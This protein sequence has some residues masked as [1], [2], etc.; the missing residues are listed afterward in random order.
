MGPGAGQR[1]GSEG[2]GWKPLAS[3][4]LSANGLSPPRGLLP[5]LPWALQGPRQP[6]SPVSA[7]FQALSWGEEGG[8]TPRSTR[9]GGFICFLLLV[10]CHIPGDPRARA[11]TST[12]THSSSDATPPPS[13]WSQRSEVAQLWQ[14][15][16]ALTQATKGPAY[17]VPCQPAAHP[18]PPSLEGSQGG[19][20]SWVGP[21]VSPT[22]S[23]SAWGRSPVSDT[24]SNYLG[25]CRVNWA[26][27]CHSW[28]DL[29]TARC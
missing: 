3:L 20:G 1:L 16:S 22:A 25:L 8:E 21:W 6:T 26:Q 2:P 5:F 11:P 18:P 4:P 17:P 13:W 23:L 27:N 7:A 12:R 28:P 24:A 10:W 14:L 19:L 9:T 15:P 29:T